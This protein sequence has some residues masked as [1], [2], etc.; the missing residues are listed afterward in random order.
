MHEKYQVINWNTREVIKSFS[1]LSEAKK[2]CRGLGHGEANYILTSYPPL[3]FVGD[4]NGD[5][6]YN[7]YFRYSEKDQ[8]EMD[9]R[10]ARVK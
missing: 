8:K 1:K 10:Y 7:P 5:L 3:A 2:Y 6:V 9:A 4:M